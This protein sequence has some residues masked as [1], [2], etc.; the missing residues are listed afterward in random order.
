MSKE[1]KINWSDIKRN[2]SKL[3]PKDLTKLISELYALSPQNKDFLDT[4]FIGGNDVLEK[5]RNQIKEYIAPTE[6]WKYDV[7]VS[8]AKKV[9]GQ[10]KKATG[11][12]IGLLDLMISY[13]ECGASFAKEYGVSYDSNESYLYSLSIVFED[14]NRMIRKLGLEK[15]HPLFE[16]LIAVSQKMVDACILEEKDLDK[17]FNNS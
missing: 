12:D 16:K 1:D 3:S 14:A 8:K 13:M 2:L 4:K 7:Q 5:Y 10:Y 17:I 9:L 11:N 6:P 15:N